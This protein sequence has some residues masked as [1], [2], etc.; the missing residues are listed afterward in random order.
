MIIWPSH[1]IRLSR[2]NENNS[3][4]NAVNL[5]YRTYPYCWNSEDIPGTNAHLRALRSGYLLGIF[6]V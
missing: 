5:I 3:Y 2:E 1:Q 6:L 4:F